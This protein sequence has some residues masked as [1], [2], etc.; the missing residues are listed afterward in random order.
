MTINGYLRY[1]G[2]ENIDEQDIVYGRTA[3][4]TNDRTDA[5]P[6]DGQNHIS[7]SVFLI[8]SNIYGCF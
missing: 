5:W 7:K 2:T 4:K 8:S 1:K 3:G 6:D